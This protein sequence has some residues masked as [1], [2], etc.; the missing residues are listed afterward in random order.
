MKKEVLSKSER[1]KSEVF[2]Y[3]KTLVQTFFAVYIIVNFFI[4]PVQVEGNSMYPTLKDD[5]I[6]VSNKIGYSLMGISRFDIVVISLDNKYL[7]KRVIGLPGETIAYKDDVLYVNGNP[8][9]E[10]FLDAEYKKNETTGLFT[11]N[12]EE[13]K[14]GSDEY[15]CMGDNR[16]H[17]RDSRY[18]GPFHK[19]QFV[20]KGVMILYPFSNIGIKS[21]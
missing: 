5:S 11:S 16:P 14:L 9:E 19:E 2:D 10:P 6:G 20:S 15:Y 4:V 17:S 1:F 18:Y 13:F 8:I 7:V 21:W 12:L 3:C